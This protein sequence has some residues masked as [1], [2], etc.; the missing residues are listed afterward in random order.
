MSQPASFVEPAKGETVL[1][2]PHTRQWKRKTCYIGD[3]NG[4]GSFIK[5]SGKDPLYIRWVVLCWQCRAWA[6]VRRR[7]P[8]RMVK[9][10]IV[11]EGV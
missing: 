2:C 6:W 8:V 5:R 9:R 7:D 10:A 4:L 1:A 3:E 11:W